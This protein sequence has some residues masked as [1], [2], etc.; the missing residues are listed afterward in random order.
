MYAI[1]LFACAFLVSGC[2]S[3]YSPKPPGYFKIDLPER[4][5]QVFDKTGYPY[6]FEYPVYANV[7]QDTTF[8]EE[9]PENPYWINI[10]FPRFSGRIYLSYNIIGGKA[11]FK[12]KNAKGDYVDSVGVNTLDRLMQGSYQLTFKHSYKASSIDD[13]LFR[14]P[15]GIEGI[16][17]KIGGN[18]ATA[19]Q[20]LA[21][22]SVKHFLR[23]ALYFDATPNEDSLSVVNNFLKEDMQHLIN[24]LKWR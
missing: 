5:Y 23:G 13:S 17:F 15:N 19:N 10:D 3:T 7:I 9:K 8:F 22:D 21:T 11:R 14:T 2:N 1:L 24:T 6:S 16:Y 12:V 18:A 4:A 20:F